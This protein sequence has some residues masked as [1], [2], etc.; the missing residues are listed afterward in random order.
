MLDT[1][2]LCLFFSS[3]SNNSDH[4]DLVLRKLRPQSDQEGDIIKIVVTLAK[5]KSGSPHTTYGTPQHALP[6]PG[7]EVSQENG[8]MHV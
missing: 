5:G 3:A 6:Q 1:N 2:R 8:Q 4:L 7:L